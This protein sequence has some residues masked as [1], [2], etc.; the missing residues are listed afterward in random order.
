MFRRKK[1]LILREEET[2]EREFREFFRG[3]IREG[4]REW[5]IRRNRKRQGKGKYGG[6]FF[7]KR[8]GIA[9]IGEE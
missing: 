6:K 4:I 5:Q 9:G 1:K 3:R 8:G 7:R 2:K